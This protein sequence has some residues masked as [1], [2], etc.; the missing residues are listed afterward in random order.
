MWTDQWYVTLNDV[1]DRVLTAV[2]IKGTHITGHFSAPNVNRGLDIG[3][4]PA[5]RDAVVDLILWEPVEVNAPTDVVEANARRMT[6]TKMQ[7]LREIAPESGAYF[8]EVRINPKR[9]LAALLKVVI[10]LTRILLS[11][12]IL[13]SLTGVELSSAR[14]MI[15]C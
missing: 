1:Q 9:K 3:M 12:A 6:Y 14:I 7:A 11:S 10:I 5:W 2:I 13:M 15:A 8:N 4:N